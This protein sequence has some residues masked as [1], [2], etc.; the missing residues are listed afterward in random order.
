VRF[1]APIPL[2]LAAFVLA[3]C[4]APPAGP[5]PDPAD[6]PRPPLEVSPADP[7]LFVPPLPPGG[8]VV[9]E[10]AEDSPWARA[11]LRPGDVIER[12][13]GREVRSEAEFRRACGGGAPTR[14]RIVRSRLR[15]AAAPVPFVFPPVA[16]RG[17]EPVISIP[18]TIPLSGPG[19]CGCGRRGVEIEVEVETGA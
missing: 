5:G 18:T 6:D 11:G 13:N 15:C 2:L 12:V 3:A 10:I 7:G 19:P 16:P 14:V 9:V 8:V 17:T 4:A 1:P